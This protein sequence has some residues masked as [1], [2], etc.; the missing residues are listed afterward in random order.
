ML[1]QKLDSTR[2]E[3]LDLSARNRL[4]NTPRTSKRSSRL[5]IVDELPDEVFRLLVVEK[6]KMSFLP[7]TGTETPVDETQ[8]D[9]DE[10]E[11]LGSQGWAQPEES[12][13][14]NGELAG[15]HTDDKLQTELAS[16]SLQTKLLK[17]SYEARLSAEEQGVNTLYLA[18][19]FLKWFEAN[20]SNV[21]RQAPLLLI[22]VNLER[23]SANAR[24]RLSWDESDISTNLSLKE[25]LK[26]EF[27][28]ELPEIGDIEDFVPSKYF[29]QVRKAVEVKPEW[30]LV[31][32]GMVL[33]FFS[34]AKFL[35]YKDLDSSCWPTERALTDNKLIGG[36]LGEGFKSDPPICRDDQNIDEF[37]KPVDMI[38]VVDTDSSQALAIEESKTGRNLVIQGPPGTG[39]SQTI[40]NIIAAA[41]NDGKKVLFVA[42][43]MAAL[44]VVHR[45]LESVGLGP[46][47]IELHSHQANKKAVLQ[48]LESTLELGRPRQANHQLQADELTACRERLNQYAANMHTR[49]KPS[50]RTP[51]QIVGKLV[52]LQNQGVVAPEF[53]FPNA[54]SWTPEVYN[55]NLGLVKDLAIHLKNVGDPTT[56]PWRGVMVEAL[57]PADQARL[58]KQIADI[59]KRLSVI[60]TANARISTAF[61][62]PAPANLADSVDVANVARAATK[63]PGNVDALCITSPVWQTSLEKIKGLLAIGR[64]LK[65]KK[66][67]LGSLVS[68]VAWDVDWADT[69]RHLKAYGRSWFRIFSSKYRK[70]KAELVG[71]LNCE[72]PGKLEDQLQIVDDVI[73]VQKAQQEI[74]S[75]SG[76]GQQ[77]FGRDWNGVDT[78]AESLDPVFNWHQ[79][80]TKL[81]LPNGF[82]EVAADPEKRTDLLQPVNNIR[83]NINDLMSEIKEL[84]AKLKLRVS[85]AFSAAELKKIPLIELA[86][87]LDS[88][89]DKSEDL[90]KWIGFS[91]RL[92]KLPN[93]GM[94]QLVQQISTGGVTHETLEQQFQA[95]Y[96]E[97]L[98]RT[99]YTTFPHLAEFDGRSHEKLRER[100]REL[101]LQRCEFARHEVAAKHYSMLP[102]QGTEAG[103]IGIVRREIAKKR[104]HLPIRKLLGQAGH[105]VQAIKPVFMMSPI[106]VAQY[107]EPGVLEFDLLL[108]DEASQVKPVD[109]LG[110]MARAKQVIVVGD[111]R[112][113]PP[114]NFFN[115]VTGGEEDA[116]DPEDFDAKDMES[117]L[118]LCAAQNINQRMLRWHY[119]S[120]HQSLIAVSNYEFYDSKLFVVPSPAVASEGLGLSFVHVKNG[121]FDRGKSRTN[122][123]EAAAVADAVIEH[124][125]LH[126]NK[127]LGVAAFSVAQRD[128][129]LNEVELRRRSH[130]ELEEFFA[131]GGP[132]PFFVKNIENVQGDERDKIII[133]VGYGKDESGYMAM[134]FGP[135]QTEGGERRLNVLISRAKESC[136]VFSSITADDIDL[137][138]ARSRGVAAFKTFL[139]YARTGFLDV[140]IQQSDRDFDSE[141]ERQVAK[142]ISGLGYEVQSQIGF[143]GFYIDLAIVDPE[144]PGR[145]LLGIECD[146]ASYHSSRSAR[147]RDQLRQA[148]LEDRGWI[149]HRIWST[150]WFQRPDEQLRLVVAAIEN[151]KSE[152]ASRDRG[153]E[154]K[155]DVPNESTPFKLEREEPASIDVG[156]TDA[157]TSLPYRE[158]SFS[159][160]SCQEIHELPLDQLCIVVEAVVKVEGPVHSSEVARRIAGLCG[161]N[162][163]GSR[164]SGCIESA[165]DRMVAQGR[166]DNLDG[167]VSMRGG[168]IQIRSRENVSSPNLKKP[169]MLPPAE[170][171]KAVE[172]VVHVHLGIEPDEV[173]R[174]VAG[175]LGFKSTSQKLKTVVRSVIDTLTADEVIE[176]R[177]NRLYGAKRIQL[178]GSMQYG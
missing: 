26:S 77:A 127:T 81:S 152:W 149:I 46:A 174:E 6:R 99:V 72:L 143:A 94:E 23:S 44:Q 103:E 124:A 60:M 63:A 89:A 67:S 54:E 161:F 75:T 115:K 131:T 126:S 53:E 50:G 139:T 92:N 84:F 166:I 119:R 76:L 112:Q 47:C 9:A 87:R 40:T 19:G 34:F 162:R 121:I 133:S 169:E 11:A 142:A 134:N 136:L 109:A 108:I 123:I 2:R 120:R 4:I 28:I 157:V 146:G 178:D 70:A 65:D 170:I 25:K 61:N 14:E 158:A 49:L 57:L 16:D 100:F 156:A 116:T 7:G 51:Y 69:R 176:L 102:R 39:K 106:S 37:L 148:V 48:E 113:L 91:I 154:E 13:L 27:G 105:A 15:R 101:D 150:D 21:E 1:E 59:R 36:L 79:E 153:W 163:A 17:L 71:V 85:K 144:T 159:V 95:C 160:N 30:T 52:Q 129:I 43:K 110:A 24:F 64:E 32:N 55:N 68:Q 114:T 56:H 62:I 3:L 18:I 137:S 10:E 20:R 8:M 38:H 74:Q 73:A 33:W 175:L 122:R 172:A 78:D 171:A 104:R 45:R 164:I 42:E 111:E 128:A 96:F 83:S 107:L 165:I 125:K 58:Q 145:F 82:Y 93:A 97:Q 31:A 130:P 12:S 138:R 140:G 5:D 86:A 88:W 41:V 22:P 141:F 135:L 177:G 80:C 147:D 118:G 132:E 90:S 167:F 98:M 151:A 66:A 35:M 29:E 173:T 168:S 117:V 155:G